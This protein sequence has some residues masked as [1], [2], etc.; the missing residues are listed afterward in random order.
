M[1][2]S[3]HATWRSEAA[4][5]PCGSRQRAAKVAIANGA[6]LIFT[7]AKVAKLDLARYYVAVAAGALHGGRPC[8]LKRY[9]YGIDDESSSSVQPAGGHRGSRRLALLPAL[10]RRQ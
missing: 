2:R 3:S 1:T 7:R 4:R 6:S 8:V 5:R 10:F 9:P